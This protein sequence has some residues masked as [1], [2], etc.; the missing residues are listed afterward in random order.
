MSDQLGD[1][2]DEAMKRV[3]DEMIP[4]YPLGNFKR[5]GFGGVVWDNMRLLLQDLADRD[6]VS[7]EAACVCRYA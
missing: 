7:R 1:E 2:A 4:V 5:K 3:Q 6:L